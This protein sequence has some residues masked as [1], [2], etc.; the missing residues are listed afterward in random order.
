MPLRSPR[1][2]P[3]LTDPLNYETPAPSRIADED[4]L[5]PLRSV[6]AA[7]SQRAVSAVFALH[8]ARV[9]YFLGPSGWNPFLCNVQYFTTHQTGAPCE[10]Y[11]RGQGTWAGAARV[12]GSLDG[13]PVPGGSQ[14]WRD[15]E[16][17]RWLVRLSLAR[18][19]DPG[20]RRKKSRPNEAKPRP[21]SFSSSSGPTPASS[22]SSSRSISSSGSSPA[23]FSSA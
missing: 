7:P 11:F 9:V 14:L 5:L 2:A 19:H 6:Q 23:S 22:S 16:P 13:G 18:A 4:L 15:L 1:L 8:F 12:H 21:S 3:G 20:D 17:R 10:M